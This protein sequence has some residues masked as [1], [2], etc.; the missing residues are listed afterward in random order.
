MAD[1]A[2]LVVSGGLQLRTLGS[3]LGGD[4]GV[5]ARIVGERP[6]D[7]RDGED[8]GAGAGDESPGALEHTM[9]HGTDDDGSL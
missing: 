1:R 2:S 6:D 9:N 4:L 5:G 3:D 8:H 7:D